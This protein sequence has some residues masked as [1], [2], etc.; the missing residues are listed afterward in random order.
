MSDE[1]GVCV[2]LIFADETGSMVVASDAKTGDIL[3]V[4]VDVVQGGRNG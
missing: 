4:G 3:S 2:E 1:R